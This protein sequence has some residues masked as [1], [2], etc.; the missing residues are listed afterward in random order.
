MR[1]LVAW[2]RFGSVRAAGWCDQVGV[3]GP[4]S[5]FR[6]L[7]H[8]SVSRISQ[9]QTATI[10]S[11]ASRRASTASR[12]HGF[13][14][15][16]STPHRA[17]L[18]SSTDSRRPAARRPRSPRVCRYPDAHR[19]PTE[20]SCVPHPPIRP[21]PG[22]LRFLV[23]PTPGSGGRSPRRESPVSALLRRCRC[24]VFPASFT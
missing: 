13:T 17:V 15:T 16:V 21:S 9:P 24:R 2:S 11:P 12:L 19:H 10:R 3:R 6:S 4:S 5:G 1:G 14:V 7:I 8:S 18:S 22:P 23:A 20:A